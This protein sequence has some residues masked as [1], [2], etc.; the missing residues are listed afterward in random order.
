MITVGFFTDLH[1]RGPRQTPVWRTD[2][3]EADMLQKLKQMREKFEDKIDLWLFGG[4]FVNTPSVSIRSVNKAVNILE[5]L[6][7]IGAFGQHDTY[8][9]DPQSVEASTAS[10]LERTDGFFFNYNQSCW[11]MKWKDWSITVINH[12]DGAEDLISSDEVKNTDIVIAHA[13]VA[14][15]RVPWE[16]LKVEDVK[17]PGVRLCCTGDYHL[18]YEG[19]V[20]DTGTLCINP[21]AISRNTITEAKRKPQIAIIKL[22]KEGGRTKVEYDYQEIPHRP[23]NEAFDL[24][25]F[26]EAK[27]KNIRRGEYAKRLE[28]MD[29]TGISAWEKLFEAVDDTNIDPDV[30]EEAYQRCEKQ[31]ET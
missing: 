9:H 27:E 19:R 8:G 3:F 26:D 16:Y 24:A 23:P 29:T 28:E 12:S 22:E 2:S 6:T 10:I 17:T 4:D 20:L 1:L 14:D 5:G 18:G 31:A 30:K 7:I 21:G 11:S 25:K 13:M 15:E